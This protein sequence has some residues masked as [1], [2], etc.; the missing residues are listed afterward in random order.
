MKKWL[1]V[2]MVL[3][4]AVGPLFRGL[5][6]AYEMFFSFAVLAFLGGAYLFLKWRD[7]EA[8][9]LRHSTFYC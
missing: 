1:V 3:V 8:L 4:L 7:Q 5:F 9:L 2:A 6:F